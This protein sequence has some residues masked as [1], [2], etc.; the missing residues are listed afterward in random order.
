MGFSKS[1]EFENVRSLLTSSVFEP[2]SVCL[3]VG[4]AKNAPDEQLQSIGLFVC[5]LHAVIG[6]ISFIY[7]FCLFMPFVRSE[8]Q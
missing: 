5:I 2:A 7:A 4:Y 3:V 1:V 6:D 8:N